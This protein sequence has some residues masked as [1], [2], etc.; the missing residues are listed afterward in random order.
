VPAHAGPSSDPTGPAAVRF[1]GVSRSFGRGGAAVRALRD[2]SLAVPRGGL[3]VVT[4]PSGSGKSTALRLVAALDRPTAGRVEVLGL[5]VDRLSPAAAAAF[6]ARR[7]GIAEQARGLVP[8]L[9]A[10]EN[11][12]EGLAIRGVG[13]EAARGLA[14]AALE[15]VGVT[16]VADR[17]PD[18]L[19]AGERTR[20]AIARALASSPELLL[21]DEPTATLDRASAALVAGL[22]RDLGGEMT[23]LAATH[24]R[25]LIEAASSEVVLG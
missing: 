7:I 17:R 25:A 3:H 6:R 21:L 22:A 19:S 24:D 13:G 5:S 8:F 9:S 2:V 23:V 16:H 11:V 14:A 20:V 4:G 15:R 18:E 12:A 10:I 1:D